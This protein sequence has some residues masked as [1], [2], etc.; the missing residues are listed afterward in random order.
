MPKKQRNTKLRKLKV[1]AP[2]RRVL[3]LLAYELDSAFEPLNLT[4]KQ[5]QEAYKKHSAAAVEYCIEDHPGH[6]PDRWWAEHD[7]KFENIGI[8]PLRQI[9]E[10]LRMG[11]VHGKELKYCTKV[12]KTNPRLRI[13]LRNTVE[14][15]KFE[16]PKPV[17]EVLKLHK[18]RDR[19]ILEMSPDFGFEYYV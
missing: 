2:D 13:V 5:K 19:E 17:K 16:L 14:K 12:V 7:C 11:E 6:R 3:R 18:E 1:G 9:L 4:E 8:R 10:L 15:D